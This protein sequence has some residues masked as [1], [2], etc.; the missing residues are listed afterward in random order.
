MRSYTAYIRTTMKLVMRDRVVLFF[1]YFLPI[2]F[3]IVFA[4][5]LGAAREGA[6]SQVITMV[7]I[8]GVLGSGFFGAGMRAVQERE[9]NILRRFKVAPITPSRFSPPAS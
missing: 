9:L 5:S 2:A 3:F 7:L 4:Q 1:N 8:F 6:I